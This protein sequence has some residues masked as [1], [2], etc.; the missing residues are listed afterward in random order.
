[1]DSVHGGTGNHLWI[2]GR[3]WVVA[4]P[5]GNLGDMSPRAVEVLGGVAAVLAEDTRNVRKLLNHF[6]VSTGAVAFHEH[7]EERLVPRLISRLSQGEELALVSD[8]GTPLLSDPGYRLVRACRQAGIEVLVVPGPSSVTAAISVAGVPP[9]PFSFLGFLPPR[10][11]RRRQALQTVAGFPH[12]LVIFLS[13]HR[14]AE[15]LA[16]CRELLGSDREGV[17]LAEL[18]KLHERAVSGTLDEL[19]VSARKSPARGEYTLVVAPPR[20]AGPIQMPTAQEAREMLEA[21]LATGEELGSARRTAA[22][23]L[24]ITRRQLYAL[25]AGQN[26]G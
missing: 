17:L 3:L 4:T 26:G 6:G 24:G 25:L 19:A 2:P 13:P 5:I 1:M 12:T 22:R 16:D 20:E 9:Y 15:E 8:A 10:A 23:R 14:L 21:V 11:G 18:T 7:N